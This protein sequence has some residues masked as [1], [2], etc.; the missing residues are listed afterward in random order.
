MIKLPNKIK[1]G[2]LI[3]LFSSVLGVISLNVYS[4]FSN[5]LGSEF[6]TILTGFINSYM[7]IGL[8]LSIIGLIEIFKGKE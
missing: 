5:N 8:I 7:L 4:L 6:K 1:V 2:L 3:I